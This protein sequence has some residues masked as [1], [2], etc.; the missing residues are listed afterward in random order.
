MDG[1]DLIIKARDFAIKHH[2]I[3][4][5]LYDDLPYYVHLLEVVEFANK[6]SYLLK[7]EDVVI[8]IV[9]AWLH[10]TIED[11]GLTYNN[12]KNVFGERVANIAVNVTTNIWGKD[13]FRKLT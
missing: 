11:T 5:Q 12:I 13:R 10:D 4:N 3:V 6:F 9:G 2:R 8:A 1:L 7:D